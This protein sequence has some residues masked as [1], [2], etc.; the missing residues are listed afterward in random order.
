MEQSIQ[1]CKE[2]DIHDNVLDFK[3]KIKGGGGMRHLVKG[4]ILQSGF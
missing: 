3:M 1:L 2:V 4:S